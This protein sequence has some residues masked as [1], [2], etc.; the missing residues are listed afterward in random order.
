MI[1][2]VHKTSQRSGPGE[3]QSRSGQSGSQQV[4]NRQETGTNSL[5]AER[6]T[7]DLFEEYSSFYRP[8]RGYAMHARRSVGPRTSRNKSSGGIVPRFDLSSQS[9][10]CFGGDVRRRDK[11]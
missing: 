8:A 7:S 11:P 2:R 3:D 10:H 5:E 1:S 6:L 4:I 9:G